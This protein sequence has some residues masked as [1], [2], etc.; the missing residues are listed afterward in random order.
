MKNLKIVI[1]LAIAVMMGSCASRKSFVYVNDM[2]V[3]VGYPFDAKYEATIQLN[4]RLKINVTCETMELAIP[5]NAG[6][7][8]FEVGENGDIRSS[9]TSANEGYRVDANGDIQFPLIGKLHLEGLKVSE[10]KELICQ[11]IKESGYIKEPVVSLEFLNFKYTV[12]GAVSGN[13]TY[14][15]KGDRI[16]LLEAIAN[17]GDLSSKAN[18]KRVMV[19]REEGGERKMYV[20]DIRD[21]NIFYSPCYYLQQNDIVYVEPKYRKRDGEDN[22][23]KYLTTALSFISTI[24]TIL[25][26]T[27]NN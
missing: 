10:A 23:F 19:L 21:K 8:M 20:H 14:S 17:A 4:D 22:T 24:T 15:V 27:K 16:T 12:L 25:W 7:G 3:G 6:N 2:E 26:Y 18:L 5:F 13:G 9:G 1:L 11:K